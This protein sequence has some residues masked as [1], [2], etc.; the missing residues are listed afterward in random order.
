MRRV[1]VPT[2]LPTGEVISRRDLRKNTKGTSNMAPD[3]YSMRP[4]TPKKA[5]E[6]EEDVTDEASKEGSSDEENPTS[7]HK[8]YRSE[9]SKS[10]V[11]AAK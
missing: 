5:K 1:G 4:I 8:D 9:G 10:S 7:N 6:E 2:I 3:F 11:D